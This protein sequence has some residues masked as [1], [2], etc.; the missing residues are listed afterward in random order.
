VI[1]A[2]L[3]FPGRPIGR[4]VIDS[5]KRLLGEILALVAVVALILAFSARWKR[6]APP[7]RDE[8]RIMMGTIVSITVFAP[9][10]DPAAR[11]I[12]AAFGEV[13]RV[14]ALTTRYGPGSEVSR[15]N[16]A[17]DGATAVPVSVELLG[18]VRRAL[19]VSRLSGGAFDVTVGPIVDLWAFGDEGALPPREAID[20]AL[21]LVDYRKV[22]VDTAAG[23]IVMPAG[24]A[25]DLDGIA[26]GY[27]VDRAVAV[28]AEHGIASAIVDAGGDVGLLGRPPSGDAWRVGVKHPR[29]DGLLGVSLDGGGVATSGDYQ[30]YTV[31]GGERYHHLLDPATGYPARGVVSVTVAAETAMEADALATA[32]FV[33]GAERG[34]LLAEELPGVEALI[35]TGDGGIG[36][37]LASSGF[38]GRFH[39]A[40]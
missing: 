15:L 22:L 12:E 21:P 6:D 17:A 31:I 23:T 24:A 7:S 40:E 16:A 9:D 19:D 1:R 36:E 4:I 35:V 39:G 34:V 5:R 27:A 29:S 2:N 3:A 38:R 10:Q 11:A 33:M 20:A 32:I 37:I 18:I 30:R 26:K 14:E 13:A 28:L 25:I 8:H